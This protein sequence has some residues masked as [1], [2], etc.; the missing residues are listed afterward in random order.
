MIAQ[1]ISTFRP[2]GLPSHVTLGLCPYI[3]SFYLSRGGC[4]F[5]L[6]Y[7]VIALMEYGSSASPVLPLSLLFTV[8]DAS[9][10][11]FASLIQAASCCIWYCRTGPITSIALYFLCFVPSVCRT[12]SVFHIMR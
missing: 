10:Q 4:R 3:P 6:S 7:G 9:L 5:L 11:G 8:N 12:R 2:W 1:W